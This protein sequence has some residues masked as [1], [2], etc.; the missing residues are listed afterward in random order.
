MDDI[1]GQFLVHT[2]AILPGINGGRLGTGDDLA[3]LESDHV[4]GAGDVHEALVDVG[5]HPIGDDSY[6]DLL[7]LAEG[8]TP[9]SRVFPAFFE[10]DTGQAAQ[11]GEAH[12][13]GALAVMDLDVQAAETGGA[14]ERAAGSGVSRRSLRESPPRDSLRESG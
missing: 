1:K 6:L 13:H 8:K 4:R 3:M 11:P 7:D 14:V 5:D 2:V 10:G 12:L 9:I